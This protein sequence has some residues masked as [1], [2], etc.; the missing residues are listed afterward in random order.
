MRMSR[1]GKNGN[2]N[3]WIGR[4]FRGGRKSSSNG[5]EHMERWREREEEGQVG[6]DWVGLDGIVLYCIVIVLSLRAT[7]RNEARC[8]FHVCRCCHG[9]LCCECACRLFQFS[10]L[11]PFACSRCSSSILYILPHKLLLFFCMLFYLF[12]TISLPPDS[13][14]LKCLDR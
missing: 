14:D 4:G 2:T 12:H 11:L 9:Q 8:R 1:N 13:L 5:D 7:V 3:G 10:S 6:L